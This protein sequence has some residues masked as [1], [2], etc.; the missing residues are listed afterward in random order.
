MSKPK[1][2]FKMP[3]DLG[4]ENHS[5]AGLLKIGGQQIEIAMK[6]NRNH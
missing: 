4:E 3:N 2:I 1:P 5:M 6:S